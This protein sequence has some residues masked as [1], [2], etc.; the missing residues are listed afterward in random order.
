[1]KSQYLIPI[2]TFLLGA[3]T[4][5]NWSVASI[6]PFRIV[7]VTAEDAARSYGV[8]EGAALMNCVL[9]K[10]GDLKDPQGLSSGGDRSDALLRAFDVR[11]RSLHWAKHSV[12]WNYYWQGYNDTI[13]KIRQRNAESLSKYSPRE[14]QNLRSQQMGV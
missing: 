1:M 6:S 2:G 4:G 9:L 11:W 10:R 5:I 14:C 7:A 13:E 3:V 8:G 12:E